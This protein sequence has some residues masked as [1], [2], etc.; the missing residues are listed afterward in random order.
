MTARWQRLAVPAYA[1]SLVRSQVEPVLLKAQPG[2]PLFVGAGT[3]TRANDSALR[4]IVRGASYKTRAG[5]GSPR[6]DGARALRSPGREV[7]QG[8]VGPK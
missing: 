5:G 1:R 3:D 4:N 8:A 6:R 2:D 7:D